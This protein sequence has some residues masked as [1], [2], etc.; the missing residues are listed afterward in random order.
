MTELWEGDARP[1]AAQ[2]KAEFERRV[3][4]LTGGG[5]PRDLAQR[6]PV[7]CRCRRLLDIVEVAHSTGLDAVSTAWVYSALNHNLDLDWIRRQIAALSVQTLA[8]VARTKLQ[9]ALN[10]RRD[11]T[12][13]ILRSRQKERSPRYPRALGASESADVGSPRTDHCGVQ[14]PAMSSISR[15]SR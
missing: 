4:H 7:W 13:E 3:R 11:L 14:G 6:V 2:D 12:A 5:V 10:R 15:Y 9:A 1:L 8:S